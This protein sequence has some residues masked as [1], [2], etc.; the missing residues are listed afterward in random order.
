MYVYKQ[1]CT[2]WCLCMYEYPKTFCLQ[3]TGTNCE[4]VPRPSPSFLPLTLQFFVGV[5][6]AWER[7]L[8]WDFL[9]VVLFFVCFPLF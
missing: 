1:N 6:E 9:R 5:W 3:A 7:K 2:V 4:H 8:V